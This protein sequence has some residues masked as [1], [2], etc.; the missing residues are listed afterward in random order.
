[1]SRTNTSPIA[2]TMT[3]ELWISRLAKLNELVNVS[4]RSDGEH[5]Q[6]HEQAEDGGEGSDVTAP[7]PRDVLP[8]R[9]GK[10]H[11]RCRRDLVDL[12]GKRH[13]CSSCSGGA[14]PL[15]GSALA[16]CGSVTTTCPPLSTRVPPVMS[17]TTSECD[18]SV[19]STCAVRR[20][21]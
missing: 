8:R 4:G 2:M 12:V 13:D 20:P 19:A 16:S 9:I 18:T 5:D 21:R 17:W 7:D 6:Q 15:S 11:L 1:M 10:G 14:V 3:G